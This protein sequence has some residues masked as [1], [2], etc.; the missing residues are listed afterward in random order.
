MERAESDALLHR[1]FRRHFGDPIDAARRLERHLQDIRLPFDFLS[2]LL[3]IQY[4]PQPK[5]PNGLDSFIYYFVPDT[6]WGSH[7]PFPEDPL[8]PNFVYCS[9]GIG[10]NLGCPV[11]FLRA[12]DA[13]VRL[14]PADQQDVRKGLENPTQHL[15][16][17]EE[18]LWLDAWLS[19]SDIRRPGCLKGAKG[20]VDWALRSR[21]FP[22]YLEAKFRP[23]DW[24]RN[25]DKETFVPMAGSFLGKAAHK[26]PEAPASDALHLV[27]ITAFENVTLDVIH[28]IG[29]ELESFPQIHGVVFKTIAQM[30]HLLSIERGVWSCVA[31]LLARPPTSAI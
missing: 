6:G 14:T 7:N 31:R 21:G 4:P 11:R 1:L 16:T 15:A 13:L 2:K 28:L 29:K 24:P 17:V 23:S 22:I 10:L 30:T 27:A 5:L 26:F 3:E 19:P 25:T 18:L 12:M 20:D 9:D 8:D